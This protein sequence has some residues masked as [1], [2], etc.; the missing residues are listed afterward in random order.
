[1]EQVAHALG[2]LLLRAVPTLILVLLLYL[3]LKKI[4][5]APLQKLLERR[6]QEGEGALKAARE[7]AA[8]AERRTLEYQNALKEARA[9]IYRLQESERNKTVEE[10]SQQL[11]Q[12]RAQA[13]NQLQAAR[14]QI[15]TEAEQARLRL[16]EQSEELAEAITKTVLKHEAETA[17]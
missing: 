14:K 12:A 2:Q 16:A 1:M 8:D 11:Q 15:Q 9:E 3:F 13:E 17:T 7:A 6:Y 4:F 5:F 10:C